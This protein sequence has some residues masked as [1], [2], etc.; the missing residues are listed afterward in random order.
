VLRFARR[1]SA[2]QAKLCLLARSNGI[3][4]ALLVWFCVQPLDAN[5]QLE[6]IAGE[7]YNT[8]TSV[9][10]DNDVLSVRPNNEDRNYTM[11][12]ALQLS[13]SRIV[14][15]GL[16]RPLSWVNQLPIVRTLQIDKER[17]LATSHALD[18]GVSAFTPDDLGAFTP[19]R[20]DR[21]YASLLFAD[22]Q[23]QTLRKDVRVAVTTELSLGLLG[24]DIG[25]G[26]QRWLHQK[27]QGADGIPVVPE[28]WPNQISDGG[29]PT[30]RYMVRGQYLIR[31]GT[32]FDVQAIG[33]GN[34]GYYTNVGA[35]AAARVGKISSGWWQFSA[36]PIEQHGLTALSAQIKN[37]DTDR[38]AAGT[39]GRYELYAWAGGTARVWAYNALLQGQFRDSAVTI[40]SADLQ[41]GV[42]DYSLGVTAGLEIH[43]RWHRLTLAYARRSPEFNTDLRRYH[44]WGGLY[45]STAT[46]D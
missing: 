27:I 2:Q 24:L 9:F 44:A 40:A 35:G 28:G 45:Y 19:I 1:K 37:D 41:R 23:E 15:W 30:A 29:E 18:I 5:A 20:N 22:V 38:C 16:T 4:I 11:G 17:R 26:F 7:P 33:E 6:A 34:V 25:K 13:G 39:P 21:P 31:C 42:F 8:G 46:A 43:R 3:G 12:I 10:L 32:H 36:A 14:D